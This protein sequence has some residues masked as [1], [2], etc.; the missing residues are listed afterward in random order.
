MNFDFHQQYKDYSNIDLL[1]IA[2]RPGDY[3]PAAVE[4]ATQLLDQRQITPGEIQFVDQYLQDIENSIK[5][6]KDKI[7][8]F[9]NK[10]TDFLQPVLR[11]NEEIEPNKWVNILILVIGIQ[12]T[13]SLFETAKGLIRF[14]QCEYCRSDIFI[15][16]E[17]LTLLYVPIIFLLLFKRKRWG[18]ILLF[19][20]NLFSI[21]E[22]VS[23]SYLFFK[24]QG[25][26]HEETTYFLFPILI[27]ILFAFFLWRQAISD[28]FNVT[29]EIKRKTAIITTIG[30][31]LFI[32]ITYLLFG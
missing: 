32:F 6:K 5:N 2:K 27:R 10:A 22:R 9:K 14:L 7:D 23:E 25:I 16:A 18:W 20:D 12:Y 4:A 24:H 29:S 28:H 19:A 17:I 15:Y 13:W 21:I 1:K 30:S 26:L 8:A 31:L 11:P 3:Q